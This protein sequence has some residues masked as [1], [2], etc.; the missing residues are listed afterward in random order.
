MTLE[1]RWKNHMTAFKRFREHGIEHFDIHLISE[2]E[3]DDR[4]NLLPFEQL[5]IDSTT[6]VNKQ[7]A[8]KSDEDKE[9][10]ERK[11]NL[12]GKSL[13]VNVGKHI[14]EGTKLVMSKRNVIDMVWRPMKKNNSLINNVKTLIKLARRLLRLVEMHLL[15]VNVEPRIHVQVNHIM[16]VSQ[17]H[18]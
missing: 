6:C 9:V 3:V 11:Y 8:W 14:R 7:A 16:Y 5:V 15:N 18:I 2:H 4:K 17:R 13:I 1:C 10:S 12:T